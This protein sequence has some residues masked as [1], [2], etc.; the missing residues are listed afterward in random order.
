MAKWTRQFESHLHP[1]LLAASQ[2]VRDSAAAEIV[3][4]SEMVIPSEVH[5]VAAARIARLANEVRRLV[6]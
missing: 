5:P 3:M 6:I 2:K 4:G 1:E